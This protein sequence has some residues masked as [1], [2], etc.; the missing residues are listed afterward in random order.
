MNSV[1]LP[2][3][4]RRYAHGPVVAL[5]VLYLLWGT[6]YLAMRVAIE[7]LPPF[8]MAGSRFLVAGLVLLGVLK[9]LKQEMPSKREWLVSIPIG[10]LLFMVGNGVIVVAEKTVDS[11]LAAVVAATSPLIALAIGMASGDRPSRSE[12]FGAVLGLL[13]VAI[14]AL[15]SLLSAGATGF[16]LL[17]APLGWATGSVI[18][19]RTGATGFSSAAAQMLSGAIWMLLASL[20]THESVPHAVPMR[21]VMAWLYL[22]VC[23]SL[24]GFTAFVY[25]LR[26]TRPSVAMSHAYVNPIAA[27]LVG[28]IFAGEKV[29]W[30]TVIATSLIVLGVMAAVGA[31]KT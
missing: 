25:L 1:A 24:L 2:S 9:A 28:S 31:K 17:L 26:T 4:A 16:M 22:V 27:V 19:R 18:A 6:T 21:S 12:L 13:G 23:G 11:S 8:L 3:P 15:G 5:L 29:G 20:L 10:F 7:A 30:S 14:L